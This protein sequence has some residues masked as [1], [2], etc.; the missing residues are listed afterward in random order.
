MARLAATPQ[1][2]AKPAPAAPADARAA[3]NADAGPSSSY[4]SEPPEPRSASAPASAPP[5]AQPGA[6]ASKRA[7]AREGKKEGKPFFFRF[8]EQRTLV[9]T[10]ETLDAAVLTLNRRGPYLHRHL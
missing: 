1:K 10:L 7:R 8:A 4:S 3:F 6:P 5:S 9:D 2:K